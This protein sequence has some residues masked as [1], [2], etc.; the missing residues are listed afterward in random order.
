MVS[1]DY[2]HYGKYILDNFHNYRHRNLYFHI[3]HN[4]NRHIATINADPRF[5]SYSTTNGILFDKSEKYNAW[6]DEYS[7]DDFNAKFIEDDELNY[8][9]ILDAK[10]IYTFGETLHTIVNASDKMRINFIFE[11]L[12]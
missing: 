1:N 4:K 9:K 12:E 6:L 8:I 3:D 2:L 11:I 10:S 7:I 5:F